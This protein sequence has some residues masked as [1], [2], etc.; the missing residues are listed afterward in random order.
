MSEL[1]IRRRES[2]LK[3]SFLNIV[4]NSQFN[5]SG[6]VGNTLNGVSKNSTGSIF[7][8]LGI[9]AGGT[10]PP[11]QGRVYV[12]NNAGTD[13][14]IEKT[15]DLTYLGMSNELNFE[16]GGVRQLLQ[17]GFFWNTSLGKVWVT[18]GQTIAEYNI[19]LTTLTAT[20]VQQK[21]L[22]YSFSGGCFYFSP[23]GLMLFASNN[24][25]VT[26]YTL[27]VSF[28]ISTAT[29]STTSTTGT[30]G[31]SPIFYADGKFAIFTQYRGGSG[32]SSIA[33]RNFSTPYD[34]MSLLSGY[35]YVQQFVKTGVAGYSSSAFLPIFLSNSLKRMNY[36]NVTS[37]NGGRI[38][39]GTFDI[40]ASFIGNGNDLGGVKVGST[41]ITP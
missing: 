41:I 8:V 26:K 29:T 9:S 36:F 23:D 2:F 38:G 11:S 22:M 10:V 4:P 35:G 30:F 18:N 20:Y 15:S 13:G 27:S 25:R 17:P 16:I 7:L 32:Q 39:I 3:K 34:Y 12:Y 6:S 21:L 31:S 5:F 37:A 19:N 24:T 33:K 28:D 40:P 14:I 1:L